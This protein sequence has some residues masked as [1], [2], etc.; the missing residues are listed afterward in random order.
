[1]KNLDK[2]EEL[3]EQKRNEI[4][5]SNK[6]NRNISIETDRHPK[7]KDKKSLKKKGNN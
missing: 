6:S 2:E 7:K 5:N 1:M 3:K 4:R